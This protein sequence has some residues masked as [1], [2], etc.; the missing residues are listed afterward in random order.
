MLVVSVFSVSA[1]GYIF[2]L[3]PLLIDKKFVYLKI[4]DLNG[5]LAEK[6]KILSS[7][8]AYKEKLD[9]LRRQFFLESDKNKKYHKNEVLLALI[10]GQMLPETLKINYL[11]PGDSQNKD[12]FV[13]LPVEAAMTSNKKNIEEFLYQIANL[14]YPVLLNKFKWDFLDVLGSEAKGKITLLFTIYLQDSSVKLIF[15]K[16]APSCVL[17]TA[18]LDNESLTHYSLSEIKMVGAISNF[19]KKIWGLIQLPNK[20]FYKVKL[21]DKLGLEQGHIVSIDAKK[22]VIQEKDT[23]KTIELLSS[24]NKDL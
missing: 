10:S 9:P 4:R 17:N 16:L 7:Y 14:Q 18:Y 19:S 3:Q 15:S 21:D 22:I 11:R 24:N 6:Q 8:A 12:V 1:V 23:K 13:E 20:Q 2:Y 5:H